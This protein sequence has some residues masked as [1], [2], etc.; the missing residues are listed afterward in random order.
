MEEDRKGKQDC[1]FAIAQL[2][3]QLENP[4]FLSEDFEN[5]VAKYPLCR[6]TLIEQYSLWTDM[7]KMYMPRP[8]EHMRANF[9]EALGTFSQEESQ[10]RGLFHHFTG[11]LNLWLDSLSPSSRWALVAGVFLIGLAF[12][13]YILPN[14][15]MKSSFQN[16]IS[17]NSDSPE[18]LAAIYNMEEST[19]DRLKSV[20]ASKDVTNPD[21]KI[22]QALNQAL[23]S[24]P[25]INVRLSAVESLVHFANHPKVREYL[26][27]AIPKQSEPLVQIA[28]ADAMLLLQETRSQAALN[29]LLNSDNV[30]TE[31]KI[32]LKHSLKTL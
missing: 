13:N 17:F 19:V 4:D 9:Y 27:K 21:E 1:D 18:M 31:V 8:S 25:N 7:G 6:D 23:L 5:W 28:L 3:Q 22:L 10:P 29:Q 20:Q 14:R 32:H 24:D 12:G 30:D 16:Q 11:S 2:I 26:I 15:G